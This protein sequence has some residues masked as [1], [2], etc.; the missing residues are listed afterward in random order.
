MK[1]TLSIILY[2][3]SFSLKRVI[4]VKSFGT[5]NM[6]VNLMKNRPFFYRKKNLQRNIKIVYLYSPLYSSHLNMFTQHQI[7]Q[8]FVR[9]LSCQNF[10]F[11]CLVPGNCQHA[12]TLRGIS[13]SRVIWRR[14]PYLNSK[15]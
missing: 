13:I 15:S 11:F 2:T 8:E 14:A 1:Y 3:Q 4:N 5:G 7:G 10:E 9:A 12:K 6:Q